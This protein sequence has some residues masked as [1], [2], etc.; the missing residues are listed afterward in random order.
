LALN[1]VIAFRRQSGVFA[2]L[3]RSDFVLKPMTE[4]R[5]IKIKFEQKAFPG[6]DLL[7]PVPLSRSMVFTSNMIYHLLSQQVL[8]IARSSGMMK[9]IIFLF[10]C[11]AVSVPAL[12][13]DDAIDVARL[14]QGLHPGIT[15][16]VVVPLVTEQYEYYEIKGDNEKEL[17]NQMCRNGCALSNGETF[18][19][20][21]S[22]RWRLN[23]GYDRAPRACAVD[24]FRVAL[25]IKYRYPKWVRTG[26]VAQPLIDKWDGYIKNLITHET[27]HR[28]LAVEAAAELSRAVAALPPARTC[29]ELDR[30]VRAL[31]HERMEKLNAAEKGYDVTTGHGKKQGAVFP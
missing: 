3:I 22:W 14:D 16:R 18:D 6:A 13:G 2:G 4:S 19:S 20:V 24:S 26:A 7:L 21:T 10:L 5:I 9:G 29:A 30:E 11:A 31:G 1:F 25:E 23:Y 17:R 8:R 12:A 15:N 28:D 27:G